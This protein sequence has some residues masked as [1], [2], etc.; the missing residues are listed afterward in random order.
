MVSAGL[1]RTSSTTTDRRSFL[2][3]PTSLRPTSTM[4]PQET[5][6]PEVKFRLFSKAWEGPGDSG[7]PMLVNINDEW[8]IAAVVSGG[9]TRTSEYGTVGWWT[10]TSPYR[11]QIE[12]AGGVV[13][14]RGRRRAEL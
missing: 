14:R 3:A 6:L 8:V 10:G 2:T 7:S 12:A 11:A 9:T 5:T 13:H 1:P 4:A